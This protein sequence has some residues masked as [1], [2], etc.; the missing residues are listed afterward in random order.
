MEGMRK[1]P[2]LLLGALP[3]SVGRRQEQK[4]PP[5]KKKK[6]LTGRCSNRALGGRNVVG[7]Q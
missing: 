1:V 4:Y 6:I 3:V 7:I 2:S 5:C